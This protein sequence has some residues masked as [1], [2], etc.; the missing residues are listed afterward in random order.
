M[1]DMQEYR[2]ILVGIDG[3]QQAREAFE[4]AI[5]VGRRNN[6]KVIVAHVLENQIYGVMGYSAMDT[7]LIQDETDRTKDLLEQYKDYGHKQGFD[8]IEAVLTYGS[9]KT[10]LA[11]E[12]PAEYHVDLIMVGQTGL[13]A[14]ER[15]MMGSV[16]DYIIRNAPCDVLVVRPPG[17]DKK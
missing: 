11:K 1:L 15:L 7:E 2:V 17:K 9:P 6:A 10:I 4:K 3:S 12:L 13:N 5:E 16:S 14:V 8:N